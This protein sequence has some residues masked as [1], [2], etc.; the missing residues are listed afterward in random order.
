MYLL[1][2]FQM[3]NKYIN[4]SHTYKFPCLFIC[5][6]NNAKKIIKGINQLFTGTFQ[7]Y[8]DF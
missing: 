2:S 4:N 6:K 5:I 7:E 8:T 1:K 3:F